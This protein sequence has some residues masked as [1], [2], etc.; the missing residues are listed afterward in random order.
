M[1]VLLADN[2]DS[3]TWNVVEMLRAAGCRSVGVVQPHEDINA[4]AEKAKRIILSPGPGLPG[5]FPHMSGL[6]ARFGDVKP[7]LGICLGHQAIVLHYG[8]KLLNLP[9]PLHGISSVLNIREPADGLFENLGTHVE[10]GRYHSW[11]ADEKTLPTC[12]EVTAY[13]SDG[14]IMAVKHKEFNVRG[15]QFHPESYITTGGV[16]IFRNWL[17]I[18][19]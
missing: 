3:F 16:Q 12:M 2:Y 1:E 15:L 7:I 19:V 17:T 13:S 18:P 8:G 6:L 4:A 14:L 5:D 10:A 11:V 9:S